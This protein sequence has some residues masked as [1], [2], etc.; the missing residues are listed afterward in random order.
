ME[1]VQKE[2]DI[3][4]LLIDIPPMFKAISEEIAK[5]KRIIASDDERLKNAGERV[6]GEHIWGCVTPLNI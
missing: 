1:I 3:E 6:W 5:L 2:I 4:K